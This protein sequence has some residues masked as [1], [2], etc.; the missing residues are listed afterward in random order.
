MIPAGL[1]GAG[2]EQ[3]RLIVNVPRRG[4]TLIEILITIGILLL[5]AA[6]VVFSMSRVGNS[7]RARET[8][9]ALGNLKNMVAELEATA[10]L[11]G[12]QPTHMWYGTTTPPQL[13]TPPT[14]FDAWKDADPTDGTTAPEPD[15]VYVPAGSVESSNPNRFESAA[16]R[17]TQLMMVQL[18]QA[19]KNR[20][21]IS[22]LPGNSILKFPTNIT[23]DPTPP[24]D[25]TKEMGVLLDS[26]GNPIIF[27]PTGGLAGLDAA[28]DGAMWIGGNQG[29]AGV[30]QVIAN[31]P[32]GST[33]Q[34][35]PIRSSD[36]R[37]FWASAGPDGD[38]RR[39][40]DNIYSFE[41]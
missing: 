9:V 32:A 28:G 15:P 13:A 12:R 30:K 4:F 6:I 40:D 23:P 25:E 26:W 8:Q 37:P 36:G 33:T 16:I 31:P 21:A 29:D 20:T 19:P 18:A 7:S 38:F 11:R 22:N 27:V 24:F 14:V 5:L 1:A 41:N 17:N 34:V 10:G 35:G 2:H 39:A 3:E